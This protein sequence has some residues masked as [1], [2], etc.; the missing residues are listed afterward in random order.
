V[1]KGFAAIGATITGLVPSEGPRIR[2][3][4]P[5]TAIASVHNSGI[6]RENAIEV[7]SSCD[8]VTSCASRWTRE[9][10]GPRALMQLGIRIPVFILTDLGKELALA[11]MRDFDE[12]LIVGSGK[13]PRLDE[14]QPRPLR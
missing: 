5:G 1:E 4:D 7:A 3:I 11:R 13:I 10:I 14:N 12:P 9:I 6:S 8:I 2:E